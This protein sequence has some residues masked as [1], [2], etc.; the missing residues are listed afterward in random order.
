MPMA[1]DSLA[2]VRARLNDPGKVNWGDSTLYVY[3]AEAQRHLANYLCDAALWPL[4]AVQATTIVAAQT[5]YALPTD[6]LRERSVLYKSVYAVRWTL[7]EEDALRDNPQTT[8]TE[9]LPYYYLWDGDVWFPRIVPTQAGAQTVTLRY[10]K[11]TGVL[12]GSTEPVLPLVYHN[13]METFA[14]GRAL[15][16]AKAYDEAKIEMAHVLEEIFLINSRY[17]GKPAYDG[18]PNDP[19][20]QVLKGG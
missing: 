17:S 1:A 19:R 4:F 14:V 11:T 15:Q 5:N 20:L 3:L 7:A 10:L 18:V 16:R 9:S 2:V 6:F 8:P 12:N 13:T